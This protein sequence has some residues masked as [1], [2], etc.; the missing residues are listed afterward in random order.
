MENLVVGLATLGPGIG[1]GL[2]AAGYCQ[3]VARQ[4]EVEGS[5]FTKAIVFAAMVE[6]LG[7]LGFATKFI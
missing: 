4:P 2:L 1:V 5:L 7:L 6:A 3:S